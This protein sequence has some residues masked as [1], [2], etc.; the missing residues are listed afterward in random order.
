MSRYCCMNDTTLIEN[1]KAAE[2][3]YA[4]SPIGIREISKKYGF[5][6]QVFTGW[7]LAKWKGA[8]DCQKRQSV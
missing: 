3:E 6:R 7:L 4:A 1:L 8:A 5:Q 2:E